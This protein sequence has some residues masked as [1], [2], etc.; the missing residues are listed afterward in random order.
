MN[1]NIISQFN[2]STHA[3]I[4]NIMGNTYEFQ[5]EHLFCDDCW[6]N[7]DAAFSM[8]S[9]YGSATAKYSS[10]DYFERTQDDMHSIT[11]TKIDKAV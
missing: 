9:Y 2:I 4:Q 7:V 3:Q 6:R 8:A 11:I 10:I 5:P 1:T